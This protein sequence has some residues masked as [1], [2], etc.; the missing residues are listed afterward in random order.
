MTDIDV[1]K[2]SCLHDD[3]FREFVT[4]DNLTSAN[5]QM[6]NVRLKHL[7]RTIYFHEF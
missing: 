7:E 3:M 6:S 4:V 2:V 1:L 5:I